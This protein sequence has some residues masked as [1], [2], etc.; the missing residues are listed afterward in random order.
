MS[1]SGKLGN[2]LNIAKIQEETLNCVTE[3]YQNYI[4]SVVFPRLGL[5]LEDFS[6]TIINLATGKLIIKDDE[7]LPKKTMKAD[8]KGEKNAN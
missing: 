6:K 2:L 4:T 5:K 7:T 3:S 8:V 1:E